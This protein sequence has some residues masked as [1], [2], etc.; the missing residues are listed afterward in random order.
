[1]SALIRF[2]F[3]VDPDKLSDREFCRLW[4]DLKYCLKVEADRFNISGSA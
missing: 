1:M 2:H 4:G 3:K